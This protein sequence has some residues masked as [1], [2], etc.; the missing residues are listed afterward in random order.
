[1]PEQQV[2]FSRTPEINHKLERFVSND[3]LEKYLDATDGNLNNA[4]S[5]YERNSRFSEAFYIPLQF[6]EICLRNALNE[7]LS[8]RYGADWLTNGQPPFM[9]NT[10]DWIQEAIYELG[11]LTNG[12]GHGHVIAELKLAF[13]ISLIAKRYDATL[14]RQALYKAFLAKA[15]KPRDAVFGRANALRRFRNRVAHHEPIFK[16][17]LDKTHAEIIESLE[18]MCCDTAKWAASLSRYNDVKDAI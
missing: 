15:G 6:F 18:W 13:W 9:Q 16:K 5:L 2:N 10:A 4:L 14:W 11:G 8:N 1:M 17:D 12:T 3:R 7:Q